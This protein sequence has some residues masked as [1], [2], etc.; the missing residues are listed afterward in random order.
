MVVSVDDDAGNE[1][2]GSFDGYLILM[3]AKRNCVDFCTRKDA[4]TFL[5]E[6]NM[7]EVHKLAV[8]C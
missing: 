2:K 8:I 6:Q 7:S 5:L 3:V 1:L 4:E